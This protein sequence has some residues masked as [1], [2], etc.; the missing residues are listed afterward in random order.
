MD[1]YNVTELHPVAFLL[2]LTMGVAMLF[3]SR[4]NVTLPFLIVAC[5]V[6]HAQRIVIGGLDF[7]MLRLMVLFGFTRVFLRNE[8]RLF[9]MHPMDYALLIWLG[10]G[11]LSYFFGPRASDAA[12]IKRLGYL[13]DG[14]GTY[15]LFRILIADL[16]DVRAALKPLAWISLAVVGPMV[17]E[18]L[19]GRNLFSL[20]GG[21]R[22]YTKIRDGRMRCQAS[23]S[24]PILAGTFGATTAAFLSALWLA[25]PKE[26]VLY[27]LGIVAS[28][29]VVILSA[30]SGPVMA[31]V[32]VGLGWGFW[33][34]RDWVPTVR[35]ATFVTLVVVHFVR[36]K[37]VWHLIG[38]L[39]SITGGTGFHR[40]RLIDNAVEH[41][42]EWWKWGCE[43]TAHWNM[44][45]PTDITNQYILEG[46]RGGVATM[47]SLMG[48]LVVAF[49][50]TGQS[51]RLALT[52]SRLPRA[53]AEKGAILAWGAGVTVFVHSIAFIGVSY[54]GQL[55]PILY[56][57]LALVPSIACALERTRSPRMVRR[58]APL[59]ELATSS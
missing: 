50:T 39:S 49:R 21:V 40:Y 56:L 46:V 22:E 45:Q 11:T 14:I 44:P 48:V 10:I 47:L 2:T 24:H 17:L 30:S 12:V 27:S 37:P 52:R 42:D 8:A 23:F 15:F 29:A 5:F 7:S 58:P 6:T 4:R 34:Y 28:V 26:R 57:H 1:E 54:F 13:F 53:T 41:F 36:E 16:R 59:R 25:F 18:N 33:R 35:L 31:L 19:T 3:T 51:V 55:M 43:S 38:R 9:R 32:G 20:L